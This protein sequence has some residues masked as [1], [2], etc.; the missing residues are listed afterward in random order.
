MNFISTEFVKIGSVILSERDVEETAI[1][2]SAYEPTENSE[3]KS[4]IMHIGGLQPAIDRKYQIR[5]TA[6]NRSGISQD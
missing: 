5:Y 2:W 4:L 6:N 3:K 1:L